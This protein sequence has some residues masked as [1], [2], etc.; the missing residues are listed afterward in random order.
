MGDA[1]M[2]YN[3]PAPFVSTP[4]RAAP[5]SSATPRQGSL[6]G[7]LNAMTSPTPSSSLIPRPE[8]Q[9]ARAQRAQPAVQWSVALGRV[10]HSRLYRV[11]SRALATWRLSLAH[12]LRH[13][14]LLRL[15]QQSKAQAEQIAALRRTLPPPTAP[16]PPGHSAPGSVGPP[17]LSALLRDALLCRLARHRRLLKLSFALGQWQVAASWLAP[18]PE[19]LASS[20]SQSTSATAPRALKRASAQEV[21]VLAL[22]EEL[23]A[24]Q[25]DVRQ[26]RLTTHA[27]ASS[28]VHVHCA[29]GRQRLRPLGSDAL[30]CVMP[31][32]AILCAC[33][34]TRL[35]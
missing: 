6:V 17:Q 23:A 24:A 4:R 2:S 30:P 1:T 11:L 15:Q 19:H 21:A 10:L 8:L 32:P 31:S 3:A 13:A 9:L 29:R 34:T 27:Y 5:P 22:R 26:Q 16:P 33:N 20:V 25:A 12:V 35:V 18:R 28:H 14:S 7:A